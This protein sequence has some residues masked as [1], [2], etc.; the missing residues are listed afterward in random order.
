[1]SPTILII[2]TA[3]F[4]LLSCQV[5]SAHSGVVAPVAPVEGIEADGDLGDW[6]ADLPWQRIDKTAYGHQPTGAEDFSGRFRIGFDRSENALYVAVEVEDEST[7]LDPEAWTSWDRQDGCEVYLDVAHGDRDSP[8]VQCAVYGQWRMGAYG[9]APMAFGEQGLGAYGEV[10]VVRQ[11]NRHRYEWRLDVEGMSQGEWQ[12]ETGTVVGLDVVVC[13]R[14]ADGSFSWTAWGRGQSKV[15]RTEHRGDGMLV[16][17]G[18]APGKIGG[19]VR[20]GGSPGRPRGKVRIR[21]LRWEGWQIDAAAD[22]RGNFAAVVPAGLYGVEWRDEGGGGRVVEVEVEAQGRREIDLIASPRSPGSIVR[23]G[24]GRRVQIGSGVRNGAWKSYGATDG[25]PGASI[26]AIVQDR[27]GRLWFGTVDG[28]VGCF[29]GRQLRVFTEEDGLADDTVQSILEDRQGNLWFGTGWFESGGRGVSRYD[30]ERFTTFTVE[31]GLAHN[32]VL[33]MAEDRFGAVWLGT[34]EGVSRYDDRQEAGERFTTFTVEDGLTDNTVGSIL[35]DRQGN[36]WFGTGYGGS[37]GTVGGVSRYDGREDVGEQF[38]SFTTADGLASNWVTSMA[39]DGSGNLWFGTL[40]GG[41]SRYDGEGWTT[42]A[43]DDGLAG[44]RVQATAV[45]REGVV[46]FGTGSGVSRYDGEGWTT[47][48]ADD[49]LLRSQVYELFVDREGYIWLGYSGSGLSRYEGRYL[50]NFTAQEGLVDANVGKVFEDRAGNLWFGTGSG[51]SRYDGAEWTTFT[52]ANGLAHDLVSS[53]LQD[54]AGNMW[55]GTEGGVSRYDGEVWRTFTTADGLVQNRIHWMMEDGRGRLWL[56]TWNEVSPWGG[57]SRYDGEVWRTFTTLEELAHSR[58]LAAL[59]DRQ[60]RVWLGTFD[61]LSRYGGEGW[62]TFTTADGLASDQISS[63]LE[64]REGSLWIGTGS[65]VSRYDGEGWTTFTTA[66]GLASDQARPL[67]E[68]GE[69]DIWFGGRGGTSRYDGHSFTTFSTGD[70]LAYDEV[71]SILEDREGHL[72]FGTLGGGISRYDGKVFQ[73]LRRRD[74]IVDDVVVDLLQ[75]RRGDVWIATQGGVTR[76]RP[77]RTHPLVGIDDVVA[78]RRHGPVDAIQIPSSQPYLAFEFHGTSFKTR[79]EAM[80]Y[81]Y[82]LRGHDPDWQVGHQGRAEYADLPR[83]DYLFEVQAVDR[84]LNYSAAASVAVRVHLPYERIGWGTSLGLALVL[85][86]WQTDRAL[87]RGRRLRESNAALSVVNEELREEIAERRRVEA[88]RAR[89]DEQLQQLRYLYRLRNALSA[90]QSADETMRRTGEVLEGVLA[91]S[92]GG[93]GRIE[94]DGRT[95]TFG[96]PPGAG[97]KQYEHALAW[98]ER[99]RGRLHL[100]CGV[101]LSEAQERALLDETA[102]QIVRVLEAR[103][104]MAQLLQSARLV[105]LGQMAAG[106]AHELNQPL[107]SISTVAGDVHMRLIEGR[108]VSEAQL[109]EMMRDIT[110]LVERMAGTINH[111]RVFSRDTGEEPGERFTLGEVVRSGLRVIGAQLGDRG[112]EVRTELAEGMS[113]VYGHPFQIE[114]VLLNL[115]ANARDALEEKGVGEKRLW[116]RTRTEGLSQAVLEVEDD[117]VGIEAAHLERLFEPFFTTKGADQGTGL[118][119]S[120]SYAI[121]QNHGGKIACESRRG[122]G[123]TFRVSLPIAQEG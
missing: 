61:G 10:A 98:G 60:G 16:E 106:V 77:S 43:A 57:A 99:E 97:Q 47:F 107:A 50:L 49:E 110:G 45:D 5:A 7:V 51:V 90:V 114:Q 20:N 87:Q 53:I 32:S 25:L 111:L 86:F 82:R 76:Y 18:A 88:E 26:R 85:I 58:V 4:C 55:F 81:R 27:E 2:C 91:A 52:A 67:L 3:I 64:D 48:T 31:D 119:L 72:W 105:S 84:D 44:D 8:A 1:M 24:G 11:G 41:V 101:E 71:Q 54:R 66:D 30:G 22:A 33:C 68:T 9:K 103:E 113:A 96:Q 109:K 56:G 108:A 14:D 37:V 112:I 65:G 118:G 93:G 83:G 17:R 115:L 89:L 70:G 40:G 95:W 42:F 35:E 117:G 100:F 36:L 69:G 39:E 38:T 92:I 94:Y 104:L 73:S 121:V 6:P 28:G 102:G 116:I 63:I 59:E 122:A 78:E 23:A 123:A 74:G 120:I 34:W 29:D 13:D 79:P 80:I 62:T 15:N 21:S 19:R 75:D 12:L 46:W